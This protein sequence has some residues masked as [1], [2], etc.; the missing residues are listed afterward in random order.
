MRRYIS[1]VAASQEISNRLSILVAFH[2]SCLRVEGLAQR[3]L[4]QQ[5]AIDQPGGRGLESG[6]TRDGE[7]EFGGW[8]SSFRVF[9]AGSC[10]GA[11]RAC[12][13]FRVA[14]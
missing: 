7:V 3:V 13:S 5:G 2:P 12:W 4:A 14:F 8:S 11:G 9:A 10:V 1:A 6:R